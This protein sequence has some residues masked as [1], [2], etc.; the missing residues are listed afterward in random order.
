MDKRQVATALGKP[1]KIKSAGGV[2]ERWEYECE[3][4]D[5]F[6]YECYRLTFRKGVL[7]E[8]LDFE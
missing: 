2:L 3:H 5:G 4:E 8:F 6:Y 7:V 1:K